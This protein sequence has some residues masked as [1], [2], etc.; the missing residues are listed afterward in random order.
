VS[1]E[2]KLLVS[3]LDRYYEI[4]EIAPGAK[5]AIIKQAY[6]KLARRWH[7]D[8]FAAPADKAIAEAK[9]KQISQAY[10]QLK[11]YVPPAQAFRPPAPPPQSDPKS[12]PSPKPP[13]VQTQG[14]SP[15][16]LYQMAVNYT[17]QG[18]YE[19]AIACLGV[20]IARQPDY[21]LAYRYRGHLRSLLTF[22][23]SAAADFRRADDLERSRPRP[24]PPASMAVPPMADGGVFPAPYRRFQQVAPVTAIGHRPDAQLLITGNRTGTIFLWDLVH[25]RLV[26]ETIAHVGSVTGL[27]AIK[28]FGQRGRGLISVGADGQIQGWRV[29]SGRWGQPQLVRQQVI[30]AHHGAIT[31]IAQAGDRLLTAGADGDLK[32]WQVGWRGGLSRIEH[33]PAHNGAILAAGLSPDGDLVVSS[34]ADGLIYLWRISTR[35]CLGS[36]PHKAS[37][38]TAIAFSRDAPLVA[39]GEDAGWV[40]ILRVTGEPGQ[41]TV[42]QLLPAHAGTVTQIDWLPGNRLL[43]VGTDRMLRVWSLSSNPIRSLATELESPVLALVKFSGIKSTATDYLCGSESG[44]VTQLQVSAPN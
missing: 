3:E 13:P 24:T 11:D 7:P 32:Y 18:Q 37:H 20:A 9:F 36:L 30:E 1:A 29:R 12:P 10:E 31:A 26:M 2:I 8:R 16:L 15:Q 40:Q 27:V 39:I 22:E 43:T 21:A 28:H 41:I 4:L 38:G 17:N 34:G 6:R 14:K 33:I 19:A 42:Q 23:R 44:A 5:P 35:I 25:D